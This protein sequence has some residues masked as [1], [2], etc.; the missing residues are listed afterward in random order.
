MVAECQFETPCCL[1]PIQW[2]DCKT[3]RFAYRCRWICKSLSMPHPRLR[4]QSNFDD[5]LQTG[6]LKIDFELPKLDLKWSL[7][8][9]LLMSRWN[10]I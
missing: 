1:E 7:S 2:K 3:L 9:S 10:L 8:Q 4:V 5:H 6:Q